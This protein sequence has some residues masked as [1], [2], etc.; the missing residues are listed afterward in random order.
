MD[1]NRLIDYDDDL[2]YS[3][4]CVFFKL[5]CMGTSESIGDIQGNSLRNHNSYFFVKTIVDCSIFWSSVTKNVFHADRH[6]FL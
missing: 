6:S 2:Q 3:I 1:C 4:Q 5:D